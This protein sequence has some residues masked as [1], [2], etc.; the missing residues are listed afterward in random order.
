MNLLQFRPM[1]TKL[2]KSELDFQ[3][4]TYTGTYRLNALHIRGATKTLVER[5]VVGVHLRPNY[6][7][8][9]ARLGAGAFLAGI[10][11]RHVV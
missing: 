1:G 4:L 6:Y 7:L 9:T 10:L 3:K 5:G 8:L 11:L 2:K